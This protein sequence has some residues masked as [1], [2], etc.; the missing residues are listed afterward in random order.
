LTAGVK[1]FIGLPSIAT[2]SPETFETFKLLVCSPAP[3]TWGWR[4]L[5]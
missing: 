1:T 3:T 4:T 2:I 5:W